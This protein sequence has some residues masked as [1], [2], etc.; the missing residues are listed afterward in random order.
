[1]A[2][3][4]NL[5]SLQLIS[6]EKSIEIVVVPSEGVLC[7]CSFCLLR[8]AISLGHLVS[9]GLKEVLFPFQHLEISIKPFAIQLQLCAD[10]QKTWTT[11]L[12]DFGADCNI[13]SFATWEKLGKP[14]LSLSYLSF[15]NFSGL[16]T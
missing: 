1:M 6:F 13:L 8:Y 14:Q 3:D 16:Q 11:S 5:H 15:K 4:K 7:F 9:M 2:K 12:I 10:Q